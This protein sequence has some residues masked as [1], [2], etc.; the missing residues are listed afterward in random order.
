MSIASNI[1]FDPLDHL[2]HEPN[3]LYPCFNSV[4]EFCTLPKIYHAG[5]L[6]NR[7]NMSAWTKVFWGAWDTYALHR[8]HYGPFF[9]WSCMHTICLLSYNIRWIH[10]ATAPHWYHLLKR[11]LFIGARVIIL[12]FEK[13]DHACT[14]IARLFIIFF[15]V[16]LLLYHAGIIYWQKE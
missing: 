13:M 16:T 8:I 12:F 2:M 15:D 10:P 5:S 6:S 7:N 11:G 3:R 1:I 4:I 14:P 9:W